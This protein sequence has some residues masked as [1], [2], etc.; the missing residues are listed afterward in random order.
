MYTWPYCG[1]FRL[2]ARLCKPAVKDDLRFVGV[3]NLFAANGAGEKPE[4]PDKEDHQNEKE[5]K[6]DLF[7]H[8]HLGNRKGCLF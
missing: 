2:V 8:V 6:V 4:G 5:S 1:R 7:E 3:E